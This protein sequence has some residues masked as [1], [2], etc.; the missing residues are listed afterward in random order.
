[1]KCELFDVMTGDTMDV[2]SDVSDVEFDPNDPDMNEN[3]KAT[4][5]ALLER[6]RELMQQQKELESA[7]RVVEQQMREVA[8]KKAVKALE[9]KRKL[10]LLS[11]SV[12]SYDK[13]TRQ[14]RDRLVEQ[15]RLT[16][17]TG[18]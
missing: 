13:G 7:R 18:K 3:I 11:A 12:E 5:S 8:K 14:M 16:D 1:M 9:L 10:K 2:D 15:D 4:F 17:E 6:G